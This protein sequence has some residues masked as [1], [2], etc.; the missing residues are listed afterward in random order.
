[1]ANMFNKKTDIG[2]SF[3]ANEM[4]LTFAGFGAG[5]LIT[6]VTA[7]Y[8]TQ[9][10]RIRE[11]GSTRTYYVAGDG[12]GDISLTQ[13]TGPSSSILP[14]VRSYSDVCSVAQNVVNLSFAPG[15]CSGSAKDA[16]LVFEGVLF[17]RYGMSANSGQAMLAQA[18]LSGSF[19][20]LKSDDGSSASSIL[21]AAGNV[22]AAAGL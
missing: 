16:G 11:L 21:N 20:T 17:T 22:A 18:S 8:T 4:V 9:V 6:G 1:M 13:V 10:A 12:V 19:E 5:Y 7:N 14:L 15:Q 2:G 3:K